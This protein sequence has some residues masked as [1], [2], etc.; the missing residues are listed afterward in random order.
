[1]YKQPH[2][3]LDLY[4]E[5]IRALF[6]K[7]FYQIYRALYGDAMLVPTMRN[8]AKRQVVRESCM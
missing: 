3:H 1:M 8:V 6:E 2:H 4:G 7:V 5:F